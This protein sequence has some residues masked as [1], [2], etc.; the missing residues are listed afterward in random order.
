MLRIK[1]VP[2]SFR[3]VRLLLARERSHPYGDHEDGYDLLVPLDAEALLDPKEWKKHQQKC[4]VRRFVHGAPDR[5]GLL[6]RRPGGEWY[7]DYEKGAADD[8][9]GF[10]L[11]RERFVPGEYVSVR[12]AGMMHTY[13]VASVQSP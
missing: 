6:Q 10:H 7:F 11:G 3:H 4:R 12:R 5:I 8:E 2:A 13:R 9:I 1:D